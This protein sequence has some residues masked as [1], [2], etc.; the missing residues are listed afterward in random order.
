[1]KPFAHNSDLTACQRNYNYRICR[2][3][4]I[5]ENALGRQKAQWRCVLKRNDVPTD[6]IPHMITTT[7]VLHNIHEVN[8]EHLNDAWHQN[9]DGDYD[10]STTVI[11]RD[12]LFKSPHAIRN[13]LVSYFQS[14]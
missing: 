6:N 10:Q 14:N 8:H 2:I 1:M 9:S 4:I 3:R 5:V 11:T 12:T 7:C 13:A